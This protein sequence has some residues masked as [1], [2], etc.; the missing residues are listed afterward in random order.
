MSWVLIIIMT[1]RSATYVPFYDGDSCRRAA[2]QV[3]KDSPQS[4][5]WCFPTW[6]PHSGEKLNGGERP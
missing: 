3:A 6:T 1:G 2:S 4:T 5:V